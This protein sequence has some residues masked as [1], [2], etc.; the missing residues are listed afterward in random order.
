MKKMIIN[1]ALLLIIGVGAIA[2]KKNENT[3]NGKSYVRFT[4]DGTTYTFDAVISGVGTS[5]SIL[6]GDNIFIV[7]GNTN[8]PNS[9]VIIDL[10]DVIP[11]V[12]SSI[13]L[14][15]SSPTFTYVPNI[16]SPGT[17]IEIGGTSG[18]SGTLFITKMKSI[19][20]GNY[21]I[22]G[23]FSGIAKDVSG[24]SHTITN[25]EFYDARTE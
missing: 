22:N 8:T 4:M 14:D 1:F 19:G 11:T 16:S 5:C 24:N 23:T 6:D 13:D 10:L 21:A 15:D 2:C 25:G 9:Q 18:T 12:G 17:T 20:G 7:G 3:T